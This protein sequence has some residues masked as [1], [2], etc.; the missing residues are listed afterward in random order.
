MC[1]LET[2]RLLLRPFREEDL[3]DLC[4]LFADPEVMRYLGGGKPRTREE[5]RER[6]ARVLAH[7]REHRFGV[8]ALFDRAGGEFV[9][10]CGIGYLHGQGAAE[11][12][13]ALARRHWGRGLA[14]EAVGRVL[15]YA[16]EELGLPRVVGVA[17]ADNRASQRVMLRA[18][19]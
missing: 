2:E 17:L 19:M 1:L 14:T 12:T 3:D 7:W 16:L 11:L 4:A 13:Y 10:R 9:G 18:G 15:R 5:T 6:L 8:W